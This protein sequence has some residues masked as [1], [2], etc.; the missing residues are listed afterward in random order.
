VHL[1][2]QTGINSV[3]KEAQRWKALKRESTVELVRRIVE[4]SDRLALKVLLETRKLFRLKGT[5]PLLLPEFLLK[6]RNRLASP[7]LK[8]K[9]DRMVFADCVYDLTMAKYSNFA[10][11]ADSKLNSDAYSFK[12]AK[13][14]CR[15]RYRA[16]LSK[17]QRKKDQGEINNQAEEEYYA[18]KIFQNLVCYN[19]SRSKQD[20]KRDTPFSIRYTWKVKG[21]KLILYYPSHLTA[22]EFRKW[23]EENIKDV[24]FRNP[25]E[26]DRIQSI[27]DANLPIGYH[28]YL[29]DPDS[30]LDLD[31]EMG[32]EP[33][34]TELKENQVFGYGL[35]KAVAQKKIKEIHELRPGIAKL[36]EKAVKRLILEI[37]SDLSEADYS[38]T[39]I[40][41]Q[42]GISKPTL[43]RFAGSK[44]FEKIED[45]E[46]I[47]IPKLWRNT[48]KILAGNPT[49]ME[50]VLKS[51]FAG[52][53]K[54]VIDII[55][56][57]KG[58]AHVRQ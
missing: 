53:L 35:G 4:E 22:K 16:F 17:M 15:N 52:I 50:T 18:G 46:D 14:D 48:A 2:K 23:L 39:R 47:E 42:Y 32:D 49:F 10:D 51:G 36:G 1:K 57:K 28:V 26:L 41:D 54:N 43:S 45:G 9:I 38:V 37:F 8:S 40:A 21:T 31:T 58:E 11:P 44:W 20:C 5:E 29:D 12:G 34:L 33:S 3:E 25:F 6:L 24:D 19:F 30:P 7:E 55:K 56:I 13:V 27:I